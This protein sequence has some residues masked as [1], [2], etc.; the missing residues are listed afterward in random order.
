MDRE[1]WCAQ[2]MGSQRVGRDW[3]TELNWPEMLMYAQQVIIISFNSEEIFVLKLSFCLSIQQNSWIEDSQRQNSID[4]N[5]HNLSDT[6]FF[7]YKKM[8]AYPKTGL[9][10]CCV[11]HRLWNVIARHVAMEDKLGLK[12][13]CAVSFSLRL[14]CCWWFSN[15]EDQLI[16]FLE[17]NHYPK[18][19]KINLEQKVYLITSEGKYFFLPEKTNL[20]LETCLCRT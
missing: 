20:R 1:A 6:I 19:L 15:C 14:Y 17:K 13:Y 5:V 10:F 3:A 16:C 4:L 9:P 11:W 2:S 12:K 8:L 18:S 7:I